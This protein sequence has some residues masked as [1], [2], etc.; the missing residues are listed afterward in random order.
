MALFISVEERI[1]TWAR[2]CS[3]YGKALWRRESTRGQAARKVKKWRSEEQMRFLQNHFQ[4][5]G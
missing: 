4:E 3:Y 1:S 5:R 2:L